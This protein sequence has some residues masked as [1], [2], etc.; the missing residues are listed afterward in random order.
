MIL[1][2]S[3]GKKY[4]A[5]NKEYWTVQTAYSAVPVAAPCAGLEQRC[6]GGGTC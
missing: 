5:Q 4:T 2:A 1:V 3:Q 6:F